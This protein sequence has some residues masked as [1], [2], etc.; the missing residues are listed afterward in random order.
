MLVYMLDIC[1]IICGLY[2]GHFDGYFV[3]YYNG[4]NVELHEE[5]EDV[6][7][8]ASDIN[9]YRLHKG[10]HYPRSKETAQECLKGLYT[11]KRK[12]ERS[13]VNG[14]IEHYYAIASEDS[15][16]SEFE[17]LAF[18]DDMELPYE[19]VKPLPNT[20]VTI[21]VEEELFDSYGSNNIIKKLMKKCPGDS[22]EIKFQL[23]FSYQ[24]FYLMH[25]ILCGLINNN[26]DEEVCN[27]LIKDLD[28]NK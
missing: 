6:M 11:F 19:R 14:D 7:M 24:F 21:K 16:V 13:V 26:L 2:V 4:Y 15:K 25:K 10:Y 28:I 5:L 22:D 27:K 9:Q 12:Y 17:Y 20:D 8:S 3:S 18:L 23:C 1:W